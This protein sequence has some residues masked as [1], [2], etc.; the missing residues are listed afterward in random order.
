M[1]PRLVKDLNFNEVEEMY[2]SAGVKDFNSI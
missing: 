2:K 1:Y